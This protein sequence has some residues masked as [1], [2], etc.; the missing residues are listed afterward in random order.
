M[1]GAKPP[2][3]ISS[4]IIMSLSF[5][6]PPANNIDTP[7]IEN[8]TSIMQVLISIAGITVPIMLLV[9]PIY[10]FYHH[11]SGH[12]TEKVVY[13]AI[14]ERE[15]ESLYSRG[16]ISAPNHFEIFAN[17]LF[18]ENVFDSKN[19]IVLFEKQIFRPKNARTCSWRF[20]GS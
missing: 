6:I 20:T 8:Q 2:S 1:I 3:V 4:M 16:S 19:V 9:K 15:S 12:K 14:N 17:N 7:Y 11:K 18:R 5:G 10:E 13:D